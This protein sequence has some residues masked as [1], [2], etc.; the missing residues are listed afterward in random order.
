M[1]KDL[2]PWEPLSH[3][4][5]TGGKATRTVGTQDSMTVK[6][7]PTMTAPQSRPGLQ[8]WRIGRGSGAQGA[9]PGSQV[10]SLQVPG[11][12]GRGRGL[13]EAQHC[14]GEH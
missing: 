6:S 1:T 11:R 9:H 7:T 14:A 5:F 3:P 2:S 4:Q 10:S 8:R 12:R 13:C